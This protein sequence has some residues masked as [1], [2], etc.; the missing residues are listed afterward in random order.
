MPL[1][2]ATFNIEN[3]LRRFDFSGFG[4]PNHVD[5][6][7]ALYEIENR[8]QFRELEQA[9]VIALTDDTR[10]LTALSLARTKADVVCLQEVD[11]LEAL[12]AFEYNYL[13][14]MVGRGYRHKLVSAGNDTRGIDVAVMVRDETADG[15][16]ITVVD[17]RSHAG[18]TFGEAGLL[19]PELQAANHLPAERIFRRDCFEVELRIGNSPL[20]LF[21][22]HFKS[23]T[24]PRDGVSGRDA[25]MA[26]RTAE[27]KAV[28]AI[29][30]AR[31]G[32]AV[33]TR[34]WA[35]CGDC[36][37]YRERILVRGGDLDNHTFAAVAEP[38]SALNV[39][40]ADGFSVNPVE[41]RPPLERWTLFHTRGPS[42]RH[43]CQLDYLLLSPAL[44]E[45]NGQ[46]V[47]DIIRG[48][49]PWRTPFPPGQ[50]VQRF[51][52]IGWDRP[53]ASDH[54]PVA[55]TLGLG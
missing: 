46:S 20:T 10:Q 27:A 38:D 25:S 42:E 54:C 32:A 5:R 45:A 7:L 22:V 49:Q 30:E 19:T 4:K 40:L 3:L 15:E 44:A 31:F 26:M 29:V 47:P 39:L 41:R 53:K 13:Y 14:R 52:R 8:Q 35:I 12:E 23:M 24:G 6:A 18:L 43:L 51:P 28:R 11:D 9:R 37:D 21:L 33:A 16:P 48:G 2:L 34:N 17:T 55:M 36:N 50:T 1:R